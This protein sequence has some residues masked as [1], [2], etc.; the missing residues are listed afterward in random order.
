MHVTEKPDS[1][2]LYRVDLIDAMLFMRI[3]KNGQIGDVYNVD[4]KI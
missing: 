1:A 4:C 2:E 3:N